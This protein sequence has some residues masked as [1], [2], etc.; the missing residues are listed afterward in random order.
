MGK[1]IKY[2]ESFRICSVEL[3]N[4]DKMTRQRLRIA[5]FNTEH[6]IAIR[7][8]DV[9]QMEPSF[10]FGELLIS[11]DGLRM[12]EEDTLYKLPVFQD[13]AYDGESSLS[14]LEHSELSKTHVL[15]LFNKL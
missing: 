6:G 10:T 8:N 15:T 4:M 1:E 2:P 7:R 14:V 5:I 3:F 13:N 12:G 9:P 11:G